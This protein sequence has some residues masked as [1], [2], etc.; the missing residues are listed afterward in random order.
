MPKAG[1]SSPG[2]LLLW[3]ECWQGIG[4]GSEDSV[5]HLYL[6]SAQ[7]RCCLLKKEALLTDEGA[8]Q[9]GL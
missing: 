7:Q 1:H 4:P 3:D 2:T 6:I 5:T 8:P 9:D